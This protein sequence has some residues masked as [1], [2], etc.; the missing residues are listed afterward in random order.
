M[1]IETPSSP[2]NML[3][4]HLMDYFVYDRN[5]C[6]HIYFVSYGLLGI[7]IFKFHCTLKKVCVPLQ[8]FSVF[9]KESFFCAPICMQMETIL[10]CCRLIVCI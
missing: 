3:I 1:S 8:Y 5:H 6:Y 9:E 10:W 7:L 2:Q 4:F